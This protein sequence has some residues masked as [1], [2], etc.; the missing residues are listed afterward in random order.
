ML[1]VDYQVL[2][3]Y[4]E[5]PGAWAPGVAWAPDDISA[6]EGHPNPANAVTFTTAIPSSGDPSRSCP[7]VPPEQVYDAQTN[8]KGVRCS[9]HDY[10]VNIFGRRP[11]DGFAQRPF[12]SVGIEFGRKALQA[13][14]ISAAQFVDVNEKMGAADIDYNPTKSRATADRPALA[15]AYRSGAINQA[16]HLDKVAII[17]L[18][19]PDPG[20]FHDVYRTYAMRARLLREHGTAANQVLWRGQVPLLGDADFTNDAILAMDRWLAAVEADN[21]R[22]PLARKILQRKPKD[23]T[24][25]CT[26]GAPGG[27][28]LPASACDATVQRYSS[29]RIEA[30]MNNADDTM[31]CNLKPL[32]REDYPV[33]FTDSQFARLRATFPLGV[34]DYTKAGV[35]RTPTVPWLSYADG[36]GGKPLGDPDAS[37]SFGC[38]SRRSGIG[39]RGLG[40]VRVGLSRARLARRV[41]GA[42]AT[43]R[44]SWR[45]CVKGSRGKVLAA[46]TKKGKVAL[47]ATTARRHGNRRLRPGMRTRRRGVVR[48]GSRRVIGVRRGR[49]RFVAVASPGVV[50]NRKL[51]R[52]YLRLA[53]L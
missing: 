38:L 27:G 28:D 10:M 15:R 50:K 23:L 14:T 36:P 37:T 51:L 5:N 49:V 1:Y 35:D 18:R 4:F 9:L 16:T 52:R 29:A 48:L 7:G 17:D 41:P 46:F 53:G 8:P 31:K 24:D 6:V 45:W 33:Q 30:G 40:R 19:G 47:V 3:R 43:T 21:R 11:Q 2:R 13:G 44:R 20:A 34:C 39:T 32:R 26:D 12:D 42:G 25:R 22:V